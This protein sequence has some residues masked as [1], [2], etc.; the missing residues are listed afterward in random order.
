MVKTRL[1]RSSAA[2]V[3]AEQ[4]CQRRERVALALHAAADG[5]SPDSAIHYEAMI[6]AKDCAA[7]IRALRKGSKT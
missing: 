5:A 6:T 1:G 4:A 7:A 3:D 2:M